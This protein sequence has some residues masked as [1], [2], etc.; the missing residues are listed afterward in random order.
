MAEF[1][2]VM[3]QWRRM[4]LKCDCTGKYKKYDECPL[5]IMIGSECSMENMSVSDLEKVEPVV[6]QWAA[7]H[8]EPVYPTWAEYL[9]SIGLYPKGWEIYQTPLKQGIPADIAQKLGLEPKEV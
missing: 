5:K 8:P 4:C 6:M 3:K 1:F 2:E 7:E 9:T